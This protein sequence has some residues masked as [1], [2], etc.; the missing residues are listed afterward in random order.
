MKVGGNFIYKHLYIIIT[1]NTSQHTYLLS[2]SIEINFYQPTG[3]T[4]LHI[5]Q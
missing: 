3:W 4:I 1:K 5:Q 2:K